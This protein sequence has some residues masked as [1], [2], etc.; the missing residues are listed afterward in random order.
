MMERRIF[1]W[2]GLIVLFFSLLFGTDGFA[3]QQYRVKRGDSLA[4]IAKKYGVTSQSIREANGIEG[5]RIKAGKLIVIPTKSS[6]KLAKSSKTKPQKTDRLYVVKKG[7][8]L[9]GIVIL[10]NLISNP[11]DPVQM[12]PLLLVLEAA[13]RWGRAGGI[14]SGFG[15]G[16]LVAGWAVAVHRRVGADL[17][18]TYLSF[19]VAIFVLVGTM[20]GNTVREARLQRRAAN[21]VFWTIGAVVAIIIWLASPNR[22]AITRLKD[23]NPLLL[24]AGAMGAALVL[25]IAVIIPRIGAGPTNVMQLAGQV[26][27]GVLISQLALWSSPQESITILK[28]VGVVVMVGGAYMAV[29]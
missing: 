5:N 21:A 1:L 17:P 10:A 27:A 3:D 4:R 13:T 11:D 29:A 18:M 9:A 28:V 19:R 7:D 26:V 22:G 20:I 16:L 24:L 6:Q 8:T 15:A 12:L 25:A 2:M 23:V 14:P